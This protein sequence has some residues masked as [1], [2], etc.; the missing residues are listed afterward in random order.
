MLLLLLACSGTPSKESAAPCDP[1]ELDAT[2]GCSAAEIELGN[3]DPTFAP[4][5]D[6]D[7][8]V[9][10]H[11]PQDGWHVLASIRTRYTNPI[12]SIHYTIDVLPVVVGDEEVRISDNNYRVQLRAEEDCAGTYWNMFGYLDMSP[13]A[14]EELTRPWELIPGKE[15]RLTMDVVDLEDR[16]VSAAVTAIATPDPVD[17]AEDDTGAGGADSGATGG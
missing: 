8:V 2:C 7:P 11:G 3:G 17:L 1:G 15:L 10:T 4:L 5:H 13:L 16:A 9:M 12:L 6:G 14:T